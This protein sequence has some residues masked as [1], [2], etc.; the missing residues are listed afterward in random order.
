MKR[1]C[2]DELRVVVDPIR[3]ESSWCDSSTQINE[4]VIKQRSPFRMRLRS[5]SLLTLALIGAAL[6]P[7]GPVEAREKTTFCESNVGSPK[8]LKELKHGLIEGYLG[9]NDWPNALEVLEA[10]PK[11]GSAFHAQDDNISQKNLKLQGSSRWDLAARDADLSFPR[12]AN[13]FSCS[14]GIQISKEATPR[15][16]TLLQ[17]TLTDAGLATYTA[18]NHYQRPRPFLSNKQ[19]ICTPQD[20]KGLTTDGSYPSGHTSVGWAW[21]LILSGLQPTQKDAILKRGLEYGKS[22]MIC[23]VHWHS[24]VQAGL[25]IGS[26]TVAQLHADPVFRADLRAASEEIKAQTLLGNIKDSDDCKQEQAALENRP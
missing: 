15:L 16:Y 3:A 17:R 12:A 2:H 19:M 24:D 26:S 4:L 10:P 1:P 7:A 5:I 18:K 22:R 9:K 14:L 21:A 25:L 20:E 13:I 8:N 11:Q 6:A 23:N